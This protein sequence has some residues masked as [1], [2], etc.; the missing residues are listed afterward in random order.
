MYKTILLSTFGVCCCVS[1]IICLSIYFPIVREDQKAIDN[2]IL[3]SCK[4]VS[5]VDTPYKCCNNVGCSCME[6]LAHT[7]CSALIAKKQEGKCCGGYQCC[8]E[9]CETC[10]REERYE[11]S[12]TT[13][14]N[15]RSCSTCTRQV[16]YDC[17]C[18]C[19]DDVM[20]ETCR[21]KCG[22]CHKISS[23]I[24]ITDSLEKT[25]RHT[26]KEKCSRDD[27]ECV[28]EFE[29]EWNFKGTKQCWWFAEEDEL[30]F[31]EPSHNIPAVVFTILFGICSVC[32]ICGAIG[33]LIFKYA[34]S[35]DCSSID[36]PTFETSESH[37]EMYEIPEFD[38]PI[39]E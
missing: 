6:C 17:N 11:C 5:Y 15:G 14:K 1:F 19:V 7:S 30:R 18:G 26:E 27:R 32:A 35:I 23:T 24:E 3:A 8:R 20:S 39:I 12:C 9:E 38:E 34:P 25:A 37:T 10:Y 2:S 33:I 22:T 21:V 4:V 13:T 31:E 28:S 29:T 16:P 36:C